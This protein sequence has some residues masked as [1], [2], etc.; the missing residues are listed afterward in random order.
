ML[1]SLIAT[2][3][4][5]QNISKN[6]PPWAAPPLQ[7]KDVPAVYLSQWKKAE[8]RQQCAPLVLG[9]AADEKGIK[10]RRASFYGGWAVAYDAPQQRS[11]FGI[12]GTGLLADEASSP[13]VFPHVMRWS[14]GSHAEYGLEGGSGP[15]HLAYLTVSGQGCLYNLWSQRGHAHLELLMATLRRVDIGQK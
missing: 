11:A 6:P 8:N 3:A 2:S 10:V 14:D 7:G 4:L 1:A 15:K 9:G 13:S 5:A 12:A